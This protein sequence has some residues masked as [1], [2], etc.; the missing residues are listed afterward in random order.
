MARRVLITGLAAQLA[1]RLAARL[2]ADE[3]VEYVAGLDLREPGHDLSRTEFVRADLRNPMVAR[4]VDSAAIDTIVHLQVSAMPVAA[5]GR[6]AMKDLNVIGTMQ[7]L[8]AA[9]KSPRV[10]TVVV[11]SSTAVYGSNPEDPSLLDEDAAPGR[12][13]R[14]GYGKDLV[15]IERTARALS[16]RRPDVTT[17][18]LRFAHIVGPTVDSPMCRYLA[19]PV[20]PTVLGFDPRLQLCHE[21]DAL[22]VLYR[23]CVEDH[24]GTY[25]VAGPGVVYLSQVARRA[26]KP[27][28]PVP[29]L[30]VDVLAEVVRRSGRLDFPPDQLRLLYY[31]RV[32][33]IDRLREVFGYEPAYSTVEALDDFIASRRIAPLVDR[34]RVVRWEQELYEFVT[35]KGQ[36]RF[37]AERER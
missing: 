2:E 1:G 30:C 32:G 9:Q 17:T 25:N 24:P 8:A 4:V 34:A 22:E 19:L 15:D 28:L 6:A 12:S 11:K 16:R 35:R 18:V 37:L 36:E 27:T 21:D 26:G 14:S 10:R 7:L 33:A 29:L 31:G 3:R 20:I 13:V 23:S 5:G